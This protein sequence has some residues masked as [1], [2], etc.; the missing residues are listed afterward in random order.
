MVMKTKTVLIALCSAALFS[1]CAS[2]MVT[3]V[4]KNDLPA[5]NHYIDKGTSPDDT[6]YGRCPLIF[7]A[8]SANKLQALDLLL[9]RGA[10]ARR[11]YGRDMAW[12]WAVQ[13]GRFECANILL[14]N[15][16][17]PEKLNDSTAMLIPAGDLVISKIDSTV[18]H[19]W[20]NPKGVC[21]YVYLTYYIRS[22]PEKTLSPMYRFHCTPIIVKPGNHLITVFFP[23]GNTT[24]EVKTYTVDCKP[25]SYTVLD[26]D[27]EWERG[28]TEFSGNLTITNTNFSYDVFPADL[29][30]EN[31]A[32]NIDTLRATPF[33]SKPKKKK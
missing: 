5:I 21:D 33:L 25:G 28:K 19:P 4:I 18:Y 23:L 14:R 9:Q 30:W 11:L 15:M 22:K 12:I 2:V 17:G 7:F 26:Y 16:G 31:N 24:G 6:S 32:L 1:Q 20:P 10:N 29:K 8:I 13:Y 3:A 27:Y